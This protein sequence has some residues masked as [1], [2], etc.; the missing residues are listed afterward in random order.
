MTDYEIVLSSLLEKSSDACFLREMIGF[1]ALRLM[2]QE[3]EAICNAAPGERRADRRN[4]R[5]S[6][7]DGD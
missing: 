3:T 5:N 4:Q 6:Y 7:R 2:Q 1:A